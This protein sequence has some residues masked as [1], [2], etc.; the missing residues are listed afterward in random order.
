MKSS[1]QLLLLLLLSI[2]TVWTAAQSPKPAAYPWDCRRTNVNCQNAGTCNI[3]SGGCSCS[4]GFEGHDCGLQTNR[5]QG[6]ACSAADQCKNN[7]VCLTGPACYCGSDTYGAKCQNPR[8]EMW[9]SETE[10]FINIYP[11]ADGIFSGKIYLK[12]DSGDSASDT[13]CLFSAVNTATNTPDLAK[14]TYV[15]TV[16]NISPTGMAG[17]YIS[18]KHVPVVNSTKACQAAKMVN[19]TERTDYLRTV[20]IVYN[21]AMTTS[22]DSK[23]I[24]NCSLIKTAENKQ[25]ASVNALSVPLDSDD[26]SP[27]NVTDTIVPVTFDIQNP[28]DNTVITNNVNLGDALNL[29]FTMNIVENSA[30]AAL[31][32][33]KVTGCTATNGQ[34]ALADR[35]NSIEFL[36]NDCPKQ[37]SEML[38]RGQVTQTKTATKVHTVLPLSAFRFV[39]NFDAVAFT[40]SLKLCTAESLTN[41]ST[42]C[43]K[44]VCP[45]QPSSP[46]TPTPPANATTPDASGNTTTTPVS[47]NT[48]TTP[49]SGDTPA[50]GTATTAPT[51]GGTR[52]RRRRSADSQDPKVTKSIN[53]NSAATGATGSKTKPVTKEEE[54]VEDCMQRSEVVI[55]IAIFTVILFLLLLALVIIVVNFLRSRQKVVNTPAPSCADSQCHYSLPRLSLATTM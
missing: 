41:D 36:Q 44:N 9:C 37:G 53:V 17:F 32:E 1:Q 19:A 30:G 21:S 26:L 35:S 28:T 15:K 40:C 10:M 11:H 48:T 20:V 43:T 52:R 18:Q 24:V 29:V 38:W 2:L 50:S 6:D 54:T 47:G 16:E 12:K 45:D 51:D 33:F 14:Y 55:I 13:K 7:G 31:K 4:V 42:A 3:T 39:G 27:V 22:V 46:V 5:K 25:Y 8:V 49:V 23:V 34:T